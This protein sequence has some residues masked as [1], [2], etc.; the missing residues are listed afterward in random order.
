MKASYSIL[1]A[2]ALLAVAAPGT[3]GVHAGQNPVT[4]HTHMNNHSYSFQSI[5]DSKS[6][7]ALRSMDTPKQGP[8]H[9]GKQKHPH[10]DDPQKNDKR[11]H[12]ALLGAD[13]IVSIQRTLGQAPVTPA[14]TTTSSSK[15]TPAA[16]TTK[17]TPA[18]TTPHNKPK[19]TPAPTKTKPKATPASTTTSS[20]SKHTPAQTLTKPKVTPA[21]TKATPV[22]STTKPKTPT[23]KT[24]K[25]KTTPA[26]T[27]SKDKTPVPTKASSSKV[28]PSPTT[29]KSTTTGNISDVVQQKARNLGEDQ[30]EQQQQQRPHDY[31]QGAKPKSKNGGKHHKQM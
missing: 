18:P 22:P 3:P 5:P 4:R 31:K 28:T 10:H 24:V 30:T 1:A 11:A 27:T 14:T 2:A 13:G 15:V 12:P 21:A 16:T 25:P 8:I 7:R 29:S 23:P 17:A 20:T 9:N 6:H 26:A 19:L